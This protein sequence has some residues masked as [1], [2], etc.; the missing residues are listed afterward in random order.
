MQRV[1]R[2]LSVQPSKSIA[3]SN[4][5]FCITFPKGEGL[6]LRRYPLKF[7]RID[8]SGG[9]CLRFC[10]AFIGE[11]PSGLLDQAHDGFNCCF[12]KWGN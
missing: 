11:H 7:T 2:P 10:Y 3:E 8:K 9:S 1:Q 4:W 12:F 5:L 6:R